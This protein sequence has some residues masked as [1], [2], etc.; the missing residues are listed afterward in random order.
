[1]YIL[2]LNVWGNG[3]NAFWLLKHERYSDTWNWNS[4]WFCHLCSSEKKP[5]K[6][7]HLS[8]FWELCTPIMEKQ[9]KLQLMN[10]F[11]VSGTGMDSW[12]EDFELAPSDNMHTVCTS[13]SILFSLPL[14]S[15]SHSTYFSFADVAD[16][17]TSWQNGQRNQLK[18]RCPVWEVWK[19]FFFVIP[20][21]LIILSNKVLQWYNAVARKE[22]KTNHGKKKK[23]VCVCD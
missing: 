4:I 5:A 11:E 1:M 18:E 9:Q 8:C 22:I 7:H 21:L 14:N 20:I 16:C 2:Y 6:K 13:V 3:W 23:C 17:G 19:L 15:C 10:V 12:A